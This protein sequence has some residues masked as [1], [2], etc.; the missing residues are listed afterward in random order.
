M[1]WSAFQSSKRNCPHLLGC[2]GMIENVYIGIHD[3][4]VRQQY[5]SVVT[6]YGLLLNVTQDY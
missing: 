3:G 4:V 6:H 1:V 2:F 5:E